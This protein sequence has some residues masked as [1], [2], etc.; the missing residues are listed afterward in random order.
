MDTLWLITKLTF[1]F[2]GWGGWILVAAA[3]AHHWE[4]TEK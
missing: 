2:L 4:K 1:W 3:L